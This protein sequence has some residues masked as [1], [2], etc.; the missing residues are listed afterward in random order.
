M[1]SSLS[2]FQTVFLV[3]RFYFMFIFGLVLNIIRKRKFKQWWSTI[4]LI[5][6]TRTTTSH[7][8]PLITKNTTTYGD[9]NVAEINR[10][11]GSQGFPFDNWISIDNTDISKNISFNH[12]VVLTK[13]CNKCSTSV[14]S[15]RKSWFSIFKIW[16]YF[17]DSFDKSCHENIK[18]CTSLYDVNI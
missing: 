10:I 14:L 15:F 4:P 1:S 8:K 11:M 3:I 6:T 9:G 13:T 17:G 7:L 5:L 16:N 18:P 2:I 12:N